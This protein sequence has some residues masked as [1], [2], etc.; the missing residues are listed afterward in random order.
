MEKAGQLTIPETIHDETFGRLVWNA[1]ECWWEGKLELPSGRSVRLSLFEEIPGSK[2]DLEP[3]CRT[4]KALLDKEASLGAIAAAE[5]LDPDAQCYLQDSE[6][7]SRLNKQG[8]K[9]R[10][11]MRGIELDASGGGW[12]VFEIRDFDGY[13]VIVEVNEEG[14]CGL[15]TVAD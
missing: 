6:K 7:L 5:A 2:L 12:V 9:Q 14:D 11:V 15:V 4:L 1:A 10:L 3:A 8:L 13:T